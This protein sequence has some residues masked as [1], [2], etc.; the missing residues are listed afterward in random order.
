MTLQYSLD[1]HDYLEHLLFT[2]TKSDTIKKKRLKNW[3]ITTAVFF[4]LS[5]V[6]FF[7]H[8]MKLVYGCWIIG[9]ITFIFYP[10]YE[11]HHYKKFYQKHAADAYKERS[12]VP[13]TVTINETTIDTKDKTGETKLNLSELK[14]IVETGRY[15]YLRLKS[16][17]SLIMPKQ[18]MGNQEILHLELQHLASRLNIPFSTDLGWEWK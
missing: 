2:A 18:K 16:S 14:D 4:C 6:F 15:F 3:I 9:L 11:R 13:C 8:D 10:M 12:N 1:E 5:I 7:T 17:G